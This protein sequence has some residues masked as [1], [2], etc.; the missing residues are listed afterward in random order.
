MINA[1]TAWLTDLRNEYQ[2]QEAACRADQREDEAIFAKIRQNVCEIFLSVAAAAT[3]H[4]SSPAEAETFFMEK[5][6]QIPQNWAN[7]QALA[8]RHGDNHQVHLEQIKLDTAA[9]IRNH[10]DREAMA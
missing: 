7:T 6:T 1:L 8:Q 2:R 10:I 4:T 9:M 3:A 5:L